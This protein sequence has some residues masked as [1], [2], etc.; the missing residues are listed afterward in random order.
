MSPVDVP[1]CQDR[2]LLK[3]AIAGGSL[4][5]RLYVS[6]QGVPTEIPRQSLGFGGLLAELRAPVYHYAE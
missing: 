5:L 3:G 6:V 1:S 4:G 2:E